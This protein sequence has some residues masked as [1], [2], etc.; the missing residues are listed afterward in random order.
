LASPADIELK[1]ELVAEE[2]AEAVHHD[3]IERRRLRRGGVDHAL[4]FRPPIIGRRDAGLDVIRHDL[5]AA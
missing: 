2:T 4:E 3:H 5:P 1:L